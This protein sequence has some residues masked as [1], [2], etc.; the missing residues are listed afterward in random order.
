MD[1]GSTPHQ[2]FVKKVFEVLDIEVRRVVQRE[3]DEAKTAWDKMS[4]SERLEAELGGRLRPE[5]MVPL[6]AFGKATKRQR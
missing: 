2:D 3:F 1:F 4:A 5:K 6:E